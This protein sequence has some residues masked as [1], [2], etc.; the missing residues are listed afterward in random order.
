MAVVE[1]GLGDD[2]KADNRRRGMPASG[3]EKTKNERIDGTNATPRYRLRKRF[4]MAARHVESPVI[5]AKCIVC[6]LNDKS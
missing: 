5:D 1:E 2:F 4:Q 6:S 3:H